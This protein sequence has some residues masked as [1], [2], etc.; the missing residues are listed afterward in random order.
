M[1]RVT[2]I[3]LVHETLSTSIDESVAFDEVVDRLLG[4]LSD[5]MGSSDQI[6]LR[7]AGS[8]GD[9][10]AETA[11]ALVLVLTELV[12]NSLEHGFPNGRDGSVRVSA[13]RGRNELVVTISDD[14][15]GLPEDFDAGS[16]E[17]LGLQIVK[18]LVSAELSGEVQFRRGQHGGAVTV[19]SVPLGRRPRTTSG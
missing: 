6:N 1:R 7:R 8:F 5:V 18:T 17:R 12:Q 10:P 3:A 9:V 16:S 2:S 4:M 13:E 15:V 14:G 11:T 19:L